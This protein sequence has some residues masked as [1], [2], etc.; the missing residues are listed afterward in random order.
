MRLGLV[1]AEIGEKAGVQV[2]D[3]E[4]QR[5]LFDSVRRF[6]A[7]QQQQV[8]DF[9]RNNPNA[10]ANL[11]APLFEEKVVDHLLTLG[12][13]HRQEGVEGRAAGR[14]QRRDSGQARQE[15]RCRRRP[16]RRLPT[17]QARRRPKSP[18]RRPRRR[19][20]LPPRTTPNSLRFRLDRR[21]RAAARWAAVVVCNE[22]RLAAR[23]VPSRRPL[24]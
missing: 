12:R 17:R 5:S 9:Y 18:R 7:D 8:F 4:L 16:T 6:P 3:D 11:R 23:P 15:G 1:L 19:R 22:P 14:R 24:F 21:S 2:S 20:R 10:L 13:R